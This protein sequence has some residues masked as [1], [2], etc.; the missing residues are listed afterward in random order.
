MSAAIMSRRRF[1]RRSIQT[2]AASEKSRCGISSAAVSSP[3]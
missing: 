2:P 1:E 3:I